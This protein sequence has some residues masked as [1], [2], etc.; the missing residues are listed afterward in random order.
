MKSSF[1]EKD[2]YLIREFE[3][4]VEN[5]I[6]PENNIKVSHSKELETSVKLVNFQNPY[7][8]VIE[9]AKKRNQIL[10]INYGDPSVIRLV[11]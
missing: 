10:L 11:V 5:E 3:F 9:D 7:N 6:D 4:V 8:K 1:F 2:K